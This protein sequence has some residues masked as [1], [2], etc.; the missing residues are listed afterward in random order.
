MFHTGSSVKERKNAILTRYDMKLYLMEQPPHFALP[1]RSRCSKFC[2]ADFM[3]FYHVVNLA[4][5]FISFSTKKERE[6]GNTQFRIKWI[7]FKGSFPAYRCQDVPLSLENFVMI[8][9]A[10]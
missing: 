2:K 4:M 9:N 6:T 1:K 7:W 5:H 8:P 3:A 10:S